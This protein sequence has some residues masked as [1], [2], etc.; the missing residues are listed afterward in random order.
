MTTQIE[1]FLRER[2]D[3]A[4]TVPDDTQEHDREQKEKAIE[5]SPEGE[6]HPGRKGLGE[7]RDSGQRS[8]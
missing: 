3:P 4:L 7:R 8:G 5:E 2:A 6:L 1:L